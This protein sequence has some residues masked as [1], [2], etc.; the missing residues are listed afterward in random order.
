MEH[1]SYRVYANHYFVIDQC[2]DCAVPGYLIVSPLQAATSL[3]YLG[4]EVLGQLGP[5][6]RLAVKAIDQVIRPLKIYC[7]QFGEANN[8]LHF[9]VFP[10]TKEITEAFLMEKPEQSH[11]I[12]GPVLFD[13]AREHY[14]SPTES[15]AVSEAVAQLRRTIR[16][17]A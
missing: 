1:G 10:R 15:S 6:L 11:L 7:A 12:H 14:K 5:T 13:W 3:A 4:D 17:A 9:H 8:Q 2:R 16:H